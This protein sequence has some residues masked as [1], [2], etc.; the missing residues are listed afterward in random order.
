MFIPL[1]GIEHSRYSWA[2]GIAC[3]MF[4][5]SMQAQGG[6]G[7]SAKRLRKIALQG[8][9]LLTAVLSPQQSLMH[10]SAMLP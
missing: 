5:C 7:P 9:L 6:S 8:R 3:G 4:R 2:L 10:G 1:A